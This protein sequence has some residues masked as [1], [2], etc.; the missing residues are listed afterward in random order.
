M[1]DAGGDV[2]GTHQ[3]DASDAEVILKR[4]DWLLVLA[5]SSLSPPV[6]VRGAQPPFD[7]A[8]PLSR[9]YRPEFVTEVSNCLSTQ[10]TAPWAR[11]HGR[12]IR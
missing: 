9:R 6:V 10:T 5:G 11:S 4:A 3:A 1:R 2:S 7:V 8:A 12:M